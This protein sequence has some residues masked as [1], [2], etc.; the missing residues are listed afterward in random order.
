MNALSPGA[1]S[2]PVFQ[3]AAFSHAPPAALIQTTS[4][5]TAKPGDS[6]D[7]PS[8]V[9]V[10]A[11]PPYAVAVATT[12]EPTVSEPTGTDTIWFVSTPARQPE[13]PRYSAAC[14]GDEESAL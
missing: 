10:Q 3:F 4:P 9:P 1:G 14:D 6:S 11:A 12:F 13:T 2:V 5:L 8:L 7:V